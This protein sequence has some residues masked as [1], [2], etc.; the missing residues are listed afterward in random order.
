[1]R[2]RFQKAVIPILNVAYYSGVYRM[3][4]SFYGGCGLI[5]TLHRVVEPGRA[6]LIYPNFMIHA[7]VLDDIL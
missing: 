7:S 3:V 2:L 5:F 1:M 4:A 6:S